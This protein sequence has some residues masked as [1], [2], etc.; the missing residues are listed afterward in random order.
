MS[1]FRGTELGLRGLVAKTATSPCMEQ[2]G[3]KGRVLSQGEGHCRPGTVPATIQKSSPGTLTV[4]LLVK[5][6]GSLGEGK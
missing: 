6:K 4:S 1:S 5:L 3:G 2:V